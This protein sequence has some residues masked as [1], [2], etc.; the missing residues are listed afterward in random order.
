MSWTSG[1][2][3]TSDS[4]RRGSAGIPI[5]AGFGLSGSDYGQE[6]KCVTCRGG[7]VAHGEMAGIC[8]QGPEA[9]GICPIMLIGIYSGN[10]FFS[11]AT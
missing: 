11:A 9:L 3:G 8:N 4:F 7:S 6:W 5:G 2:G 10:C 1:K